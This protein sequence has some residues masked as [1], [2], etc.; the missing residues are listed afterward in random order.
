MIA[1]S[2]GGRDG[3]ANAHSV[4]RDS[5]P[6][7]TAGDAPC[8]FGFGGSSDAADTRR[9]RRSFTDGSASRPHG[10]MRVGELRRQAA[11]GCRLPC[12]AARRRAADARDRPGAVPPRQHSRS[13]CGYSAG[14]GASAAPPCRSSPAQPR[15]APCCP[16]WSRGRCCSC[17]RGSASR[18]AARDPWPQRMTPCR[19]SARASSCVLGWTSSWSPRRIVG[20]RTR[21]P[22]SHESCRSTEGFW[23]MSTYSY[24]TPTRSR[25]ADY[26]ADAAP[27]AAVD[28]QR[29]A[30]RRRCAASGVG[31]GGHGRLTSRAGRLRFRRGRRTARRCRG[32]GARTGSRGWRRWCRPD[33]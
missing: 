14:Y 9:R 23:S 4:G 32:R 24:G 25:A 11:R 8:A 20:L 19:A 3:I 31:G 6:R 18:G 2:V 15:S 33:R 10:A 12:P 22:V 16:R 21:P 30:R 13:S 17:P 29:H 5:W 7:A 26:L 27:A 28:G 1:V